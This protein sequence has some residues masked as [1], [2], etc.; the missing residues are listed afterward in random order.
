MNKI[1][2]SQPLIDEDVVAE[3]LDSLVNTGWLTSGP[4]VQALEAEVRAYTG[5][6]PVVCVNSWTSGAMLAL[7]WFG[8]G[9]GDEVI[10]PAYT[11]AATALCALNIGARV[12]MVDVLDDFTLDP[13]QL[14][15][16]I[17]PRTRAI[18]PVDLGGWPADYDRIKSILEDEQVRS[19]FSPA[20]Q[21]QE[22]LGR[23]LILA[24]AAHSIGAHY[25]GRKS[26][27][28]ADITVLSFHSVKNITTGEG[29]AVCLQ[30]PAA[31]DP[32]AE[33][34]FM[35]LYSLNGQSKSTYEKNIPGDWRYDIVEQGLKV[36]MPDL[37]AA[38]GLA[39]IRKYDRQLLP[40]RFELFRLYLE[41]LGASDR[42]RLP[43]LQNGVGTVSSAHLFLLRI[44]G[45]TEAGRDRII[46]DMAREGIGLNVH[47]IPLPMM[48]LF[49][50]LG[51]SMDDYPNTLRLYMN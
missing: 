29:G 39:Q 1:P 15:R 49:R 35:K 10:I 46:A 7:K 23:P 50:R 12:V 13:E 16:A 8:V 21:A 27:V 20:T 38:V 6:Q 33:Y 5:A 22:K 19:R 48:T 28:C 2:F 4:K 40:E 18:I 9:A 24:D 26:G 42:M 34:R 41:L 14:E 3:V 45:M 43:R 31:F 51:F 44:D 11:Y 47:Y 25:R 32:E 30:L 17:T 36:N 37:S